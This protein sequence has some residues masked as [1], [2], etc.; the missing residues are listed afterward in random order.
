MFLEESVWLRRE[1]AS[2]ELRSGLPVLNV[3]S[4]SEKARRHGQPFIAENVLDP[5]ER[6]GLRVMNLD[7]KD[8]PGVDIVID[9]VASE[10]PAGEVGRFPLVLCNNVLSA[11][12][13]VRAL[14]RAV[15][16]LVE[17][18]GHLVL[19]TPGSYRVRKDPIDNGFRATP[20]RLVA[21]LREASDRPLH[22][23]RSE[24]LRVDD[25]GEYRR[26]LLRPLSTAAVAGRH[27]RVPGLA[28]RVRWRIRPLRWR[29]SCVIVKVGRAG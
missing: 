28:E 21:M 8:E 15:T 25:P 10:D 6:R 20:R 23:V 27:V 3:G 5:L 22:E 7:I 19:S 9:L 12:P 18:N 1:L 17:E 24:S 11:V 14:L 29:E 13:D 4:S 2:I 26:G 16:Q